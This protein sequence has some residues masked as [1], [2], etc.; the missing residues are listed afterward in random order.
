MR[1][2]PVLDLF[3]AA[4]ILI[5]MVSHLGLEKLV[6]GGFGV[7]IFFFLSG[8]LII[9]LMR[10]EHA[11]TGRV[12]LRD[13]YIKR[14]IRIIP[15]MFL[16]M[17]FA[18]VLLQAGLIGGGWSFWGATRDALFL[19]NYHWPWPQ[20]SGLP[21]PLW[22][23]DVEEH[24]YILFSAV[25]VVL[26]ARLLPRQAALL[27][28][29]AC[30]LILGA[31]MFEVFVNGEIVNTYYWSHTRMDSILFG[32]CLAFWNN[33]LLD[34]KA[35]RP[36][37]IHVAAALGILV[38][39]LLIRNNLFR[40]TIRYSLQGAALFVLFSYALNSQG[41]LVRLASN[42]GIQTTALL[43]Y[44]LYLVHVPILK[45]IQNLAPAISPVIVGLLCFALSYLYAW[46]MR[47]LVE[48]PLANW[49]R[50]LV[51]APHPMAS[52]TGHLAFPPLG[53]GRRVG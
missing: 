39:C 31:R 3:R 49:R 37:L 10:V 26:L 30:G 17:G 52:T 13:F 1:H 4:A 48:K 11:T 6:P 5:V 20:E 36:R 51:A 12:S 16:T 8:F 24:F 15:P 29:V 19:T 22:S 50:S 18:I 43:S 33:P 38:V 27:C 42:R 40:E 2:Q 46:A 21:M 9:S 23:L 41:A 14:T 25:Y 32:G 53:V 44:T 47:A 34:D 28:F 45:M 7:T 35:W